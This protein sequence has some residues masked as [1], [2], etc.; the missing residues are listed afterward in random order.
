MS[1]LPATI[2]VIKRNT[3]A[4]QGGQCD[5]LGLSI[6]WGNTT[7]VIWGSSDH[8]EAQRIQ[9]SR[10]VPIVVDRRSRSNA[11]SSTHAAVL[12]QHNANPTT[13]FDLSSPESIK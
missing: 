4:V 12:Q 9:L 1:L 7:T 5:M 2:G 3:L 10:P 11:T 6:S 13:L 8:D